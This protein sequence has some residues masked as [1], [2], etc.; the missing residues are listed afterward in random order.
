VVHLGD[1]RRTVLLHWLAR[2]EPED[3]ADHCR[4]RPPRTEYPPGTPGLPTWRPPRR[5]ESA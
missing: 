2:G 4:R 1:L 3:F 5:K